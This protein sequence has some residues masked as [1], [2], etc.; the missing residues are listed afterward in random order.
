M[1]ATPEPVGTLEVALVHCARLLASDPAAAVEQ[2]TEILKVAPN[3]PVATLQLGL[4]LGRTGRG[5]E[6]LTALRRAVSLKADMP[7]AWRAIGDHLSA[8]GDADGAD[9]AYAQHVKTATRDPRLMHAAAALCE[10]RIPVAEALL[11]EHLKVHPTDVAA[12]RMLAEVA[13]RLGR[14]EDAVNLLAR[15]LELAPTFLAARHNYAFVLHRAGRPAE[16][17]AEVERLLTIEPRNP[18]FRSLKAAILAR[19]G[20]VDSALAMYAELLEQYPRHAR[21][22]MSYGHALKTAGR[23]PQCIE[24]YRRTLALAPNLGE[25]WWS[26]AN[27]KTFRFTVQD[28]EEMLRQLTRTDLTIEDRFHFHFSAGKALE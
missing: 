16:A 19:V 7:D 3:H 26:L 23:Q 5:D 14:Y 25:A 1:S 12:I 15:C 2:A 13:A 4:A 28:L 20:E 17:L 21:A 18:G 9:A 22:W 10:K 8:L 27:L 6:A 11:R 24:A